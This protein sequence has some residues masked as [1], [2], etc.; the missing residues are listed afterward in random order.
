M[1]KRRTRS[2]KMRRMMKGGG[3]GEDDNFINENTAEGLKLYLNSIRDNIINDIH[4][5]NK[6]YIKSNIKTNIDKQINKLIFIMKIL[7]R[8]ITNNRSS[9]DDLHANSY[10]TND[11][12][13]KNE[14][15]FADKIQ[16]MITDFI[17]VIEQYEDNE[18]KK[19]S[20]KYIVCT[21]CR[22][23]I[24]YS[25]D[26]FYQSQYILTPL[27]KRVIKYTDELEIYKIKIAIIER[28][29]GNLNNNIKEH[30]KHHEETAV[31]ELKKEMKSVDEKDKEAERVA[32]E[33]GIRNEAGDGGRGGRGADEV[34]SS[35]QVRLEVQD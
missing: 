22:N 19:N 4:S 2:K 34:V 6:P 5:D 16:E 8:I 33:M 27:L 31:K 11:G 25:K 23:I 17:K 1:E 28:I 24:N 30:M 21:I 7:L 35:D 18:T 13:I 10:L 29:F 20:Y 15:N 26:T 14:S 12:D 3:G 9:H 32:E